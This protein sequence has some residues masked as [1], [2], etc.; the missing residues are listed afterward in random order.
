MTAVRAI[1]DRLR[2]DPGLAWALIAVAA[3]IALYAPTLGRGVI[4][5]DDPWLYGDNWI[6]QHPSASSLHAI[7]F[8]TSASTRFVLGAEYLPVRDL[9]VMC[10]FAVWGHWYPG[11]HLTNL[12]LYLASIGLWFAVLDG[13]GIDRRVAGLAILLWALHPSHAESVAWLSERK[14]LLGM[15][16]AGLAGLGYVRFRSGRRLPWLVL[17]M[18]ATLAA[19]WSKAP[20]AFAIA[21]LAGLELVLPSGR[22]SWRRSLAGLGAI[23]TVGIAA[24]IP[25]LLVATNS[26]VVGATDHA[27]AGFLAMAVGVHGV[28]LRIAAMALPNAV[29][30]PISIAGPTTL[31]L[32]IGTLGLLTVT[33]VL[34]APRAWQ[35]SVTLRA[36]AVIWLC[37][38]LPVSRLVLPLRAVLVND[39][40]LL[41]PT[42]GFVLAIAVGLHAIASV[43]A[44][45]ALIAVVVLAAALRTLDA[46]STWR[47]GRTLWERA[48]ASNPADGDAWS[49]Y[50]EALMDDGDPQRAMEVVATG[51]RLSRA[52]R[53][54]MRK[55][56]LALK[57]GNDRAHAEE[58]MR[59]A[60]D[61]G[62]PKAMT[63]LALLLLEDGKPAD[64]IAWARK[65]T[66]VAPSYANGYRI[67]GK[68]ELASQLPGEALASFEHAH[69]LSP[70]D[71]GNRYNLGLALQQLHR[72]DE[73]RPHFEACVADP[74]LADRARAALA[75]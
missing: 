48:V 68:V 29:S 37:G 8:D 55:A 63:N 19:V 52:P 33:A 25:V 43:G 30:Y 51:L 65:A 22:G 9:S 13:F 45:R 28:Y 47:D 49:M 67:R 15:T 26:Q 62:E 14:G 20:A 56:L 42:L 21:A 12:A 18:V 46:E 2:R 69:A 1:V 41:F 32:V 5:L 70:G 7:F 38:W 50:S 58:L 66:E 23:A 3:A 61:A 36:A 74:A 75:Q 24:F 27:P 16:A 34:A 60:A 11:F 10:D 72:P 59:V 73:A 64:A 6:V 31:D 54:L 40:Y 53:L 57:Y 44:R 39:R 4:N 35:P 71:L 17:A